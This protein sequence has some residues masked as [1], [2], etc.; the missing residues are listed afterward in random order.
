MQLRNIGVGVATNVVGIAFHLHFNVKNKF[1][2]KQ[3]QEQ[4]QEQQKQQQ[5][6]QQ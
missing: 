5:Q 4:G 3:Q 1:F 6:Q 2:L